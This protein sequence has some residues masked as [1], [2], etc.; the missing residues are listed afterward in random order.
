MGATGV[1]L[2]GCDQVVELVVAG[3]TELDPAGAPTNTSG[4]GADRRGEVQG[5]ERLVGVR[6]RSAGQVCGLYRKGQLVRVPV[7]KARSGAAHLV[8]ARPGAG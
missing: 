4:E 7:V 1:L 8:A 6:D 3:D 2:D 5:D